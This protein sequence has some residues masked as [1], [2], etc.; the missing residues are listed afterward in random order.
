[1]GARCV[2]FLG[3]SLPRALATALLDADY[4]PP[5]KHGDVYRV[6]RGFD[7]STHQIAL[8]PQGVVKGEHWTPTNVPPHAFAGNANTPERMQKIAARYG[9]SLPEDNF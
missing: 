9:H 8:T 7:I 6:L 1:M 5:A 4:R 3:P 2:V